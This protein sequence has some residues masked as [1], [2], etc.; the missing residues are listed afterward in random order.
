VAIFITI[1][2]YNMIAEASRDALDPKLKS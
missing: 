1:T 2:I